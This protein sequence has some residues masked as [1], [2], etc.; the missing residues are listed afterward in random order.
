MKLSQSF[1]MVGFLIMASLVYGQ[2]AKPQEIKSKLTQEQIRKSQNIPAL[3]PP[4]TPFDSD[5]KAKAVYLE[6]YQTAYR[7]FL[8]GLD[9]QGMDFPDKSLFKAYLQGQ[10]DGISQ[11]L[12]DQM[13]DLIF[14]PSSK[15]YTG[16]I[17]TPERS[18]VP[19]INSDAGLY[20]DA[21]KADVHIK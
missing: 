3:L 16:R 17:A 9:Y 14:H 8:A 10:K 4:T 18:R 1:L 19:W 5:P 11:A 20:I 12:R 7:Y 21:S 15:D 13:K 2:E 6:N